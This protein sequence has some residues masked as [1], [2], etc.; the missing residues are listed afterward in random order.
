ML[1]TEQN[2]FP[3]CSYQFPENFWELKTGTLVC[4]YQFP[5]NFWE[6]KTGTL[7]TASCF[8]SVH[9]DGIRFIAVP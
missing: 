7:A 4:S 5:E 8:A 9:D 1:I 6:L 3:V 2:K